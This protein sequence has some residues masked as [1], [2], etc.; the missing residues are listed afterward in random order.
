MQTPFQERDMHYLTSTRDLPSEAKVGF[1][2]M[3]LYALYASI[4]ALLN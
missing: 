1:Y 3:D 2:G 4:R